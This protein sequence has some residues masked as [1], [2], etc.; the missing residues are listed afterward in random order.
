MYTVRYSYALYKIWRCYSL[1]NFMS[2]GTVSYNE[3]NSN[4]NINKF[5]IALRLELATD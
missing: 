4:I 5:P 2:Y 1:P 3:F